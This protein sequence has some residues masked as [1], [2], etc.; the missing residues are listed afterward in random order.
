MLGLGFDIILDLLV[1]VAM[2]SFVEAPAVKAILKGYLLR[3]MT[4]GYFSAWTRS[5]DSISR[6]RSNNEI[7]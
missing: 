7:V 6:F 5:E 2:E 1:L 3:F 4:L